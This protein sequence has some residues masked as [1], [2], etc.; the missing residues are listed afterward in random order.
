MD[1]TVVEC[2]FL[3]GS[4]YIEIVYT[5][6]EVLYL[7]VLYSEPWISS[8]SSLEVECLVG[9]R[10]VDTVYNNLANVK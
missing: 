7:G 1:E 6:A 8:F 3:N 9:S 5:L 4:C 10:V 2:Q